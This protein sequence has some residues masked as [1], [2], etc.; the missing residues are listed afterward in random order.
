MKKSE[1]FVAVV[2]LRARTP[3]KP[4]EIFK[5]LL[6]IL[7]IRSLELKSWEQEIEKV[8][9]DGIVKQLTTVRGDLRYEDII[10]DIDL[11]LKRIP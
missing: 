10:A 7:N 5:D 9:A 6:S 2:I 11:I 3:Q 1:I 8:I 4:T